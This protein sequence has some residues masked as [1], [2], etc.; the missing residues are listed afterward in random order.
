VPSRVQWPGILY[1]AIILW[2]LNSICYSS[3]VMQATCI[4][5]ISPLQSIMTGLALAHNSQEAFA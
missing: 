4:L 3:L 2:V 1:L 5:R